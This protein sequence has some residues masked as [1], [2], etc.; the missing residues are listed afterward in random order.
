MPHIHELIDFIAEIYVVH[1]N[2]VLL[3]KHK[4]V[5][6]WLPIGGHIEL[7]EDPIQ[8]L[9]REIKEESGLEE[10]ELVH[11]IKYAKIDKTNAFVLL[12]LLPTPF[13]MDIHCYTGGKHKH[14][15]LTYIGKSKTDKVKTLKSESDELR[16]FSIDDLNNQKNKFLPVIRYCAR[17]AIE[18]AEK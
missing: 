16:W 9:K 15:D 11:Q 14:I 12:K 5:K 6:Q 18:I 4:T 7:N 10:I 13:F 3:T 17:K 1:S 8:A 2:K